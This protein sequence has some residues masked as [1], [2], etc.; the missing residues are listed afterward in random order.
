MHTWSTYYV[1]QLQFEV[2]RGGYDGDVALDDIKITNG[3]SAL[4]SGRLGYR[5]ILPYVYFSRYIDRTGVR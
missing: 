3:K 4:L 1:W 5:Q 2:V